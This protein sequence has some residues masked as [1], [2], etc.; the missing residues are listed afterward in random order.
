MKDP[1]V[2]NLENDFHLTASSPLID[3]GASLTSV[4]KDFDGNTRPQGSGY[5]IGAYEYLSG[6]APSPTLSP[7]PSAIK[8]VC[9]TG[10][11]HF[12]TINQAVNTAVPGD[13][14]EV[15]SGIYNESLNITKSGTNNN[16]ITLR[17][18]ANDIVWIDGSNL[19]NLSNINL[20]N[21]AYWQ[22][23]GLKLRYAGNFSSSACA[24]THVDGITV[25]VGG[26]DILIQKVE[27]K[28]PS[29]DGVDLEGGNY[30]IK[31]YDSE[32]YDMRQ[33]NPCWEGDGHGI[34][35]LQANN[36]SPTHDILV[37][38]NYVHDAHG[39]ACLATADFSSLGD[40][41]PTNIIF[42]YNHVQDCTNGIKINTDSI[43][44]YNLVTDTGKYTTSPDKP[45]N[46]F[47]AFTHDY[48]NNVS[49]MQVYN[50]TVVGYNNSYSFMVSGAFK[51]QTVTVFKNN[52]AYQPR[53]YYVRSNN[54]TFNNKGNNLFFGKSAASFSG[55]TADSSSLFEDPLFI[56][57][58][59]YDYHLSEN[60]PAIDGGVLI[61][62]SQA[63]LGNSPDIGAF[64]SDGTTPP[65]SPPVP[66]D[67]NTDGNVD[68]L[69]YIIW[70]N[71]YNTQTNNGPS[72]GD[73]NSNGFV[74]GLD[75]VIWL[76][77]YNP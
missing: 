49:N 67:A 36:V 5:D 27:I 39:K 52:I 57:S 77:N 74:D 62:S 66:G 24:Y 2:V 4:D 3:R 76:N 34:H 37:K 13:I 41:H 42:E 9:K 10:N 20:N 61:Y 73:F 17:A 63:Y 59:S 56:D 8:T 11:C 7:S 55:Y 12:S 21:S 32:I 33:D 40:P 60:S 25:G 35:V 16:W 18:K 75:Y 15:Y 69:D 23:I 44:R 31:I 43:F 65:T 47:Q 70:L 45:D 30:N 26:H 28:E 29:G 19:A 51:N 38:G 71:H 64:E 72:Y 14:I 68:G 48:D 54:T 53:S 50:N 22:I 58:A 46:G 6:P 1:K